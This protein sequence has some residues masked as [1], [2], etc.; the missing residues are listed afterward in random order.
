MVRETAI[1]SVEKLFIGSFDRFWTYYLFIYLF[2]YLYL[3][4]YGNNLKLT[5]GLRLR[6]LAKAE[7]LA[8]GLEKLNLCIHKKII[9][10]LLLP[11]G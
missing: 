6:Q 9:R 3:F 4:I 1:E 11:W 10:P 2:I 5:R 8:I 7:T